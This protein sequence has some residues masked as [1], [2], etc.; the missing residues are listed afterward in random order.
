MKSSCCS[1]KAPFWPAAKCFDYLLRPRQLWSQTPKIG[2]QVL[3]GRPR[4]CS[5]YQIIKNLPHIRDRLFAAL[6][7]SHVLP[8]AH[9]RFTA[10]GAWHV[11]RPARRAFTALGAWHDEIRHDA[12]T[13]NCAAGI[14]PPERPKIGDQRGFHPRRPAAKNIGLQGIAHHD[15]TR[16]ISVRRQP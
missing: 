15:N 16:R 9:G 8:P 11:Y 6:R 7:A 4:Q 12:G 14:H 10:L 2:L 13:F 5:E 3:P 1:P